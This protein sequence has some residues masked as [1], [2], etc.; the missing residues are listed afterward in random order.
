M[1]VQVNGKEYDV[2]FRRIY[3]KNSKAD[4]TNNCPEGFL[5]DTSCSIKE[6]KNGVAPK[7]WR[8][9]SKDFS[10]LSLKDKFSK[11]EGQKIALALA[12]KK[13]PKKQRINFWNKFLKK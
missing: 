3:R 11:K 13:F 10:E 6:V 12:V 9:V 5:I 8:L 2:R 4:G 1:K 7:E